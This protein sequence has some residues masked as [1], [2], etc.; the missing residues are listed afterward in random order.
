MKKLMM[1][2]VALLAVAAFAVAGEEKSCNHA[3]GEATA[4]AGDHS[5]AEPG[6]MHANCPLKGKKIAETADVTLEGK[7]LCRHCNL[8][9]QDTCEKVFQPA[10]SE[11]LIAI[12]SGSDLKAAEAVAEHG[13]A[14]IS[15][16]GKLVKAEDGSQMLKI[17]KAKKKA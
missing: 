16:S 1:L 9:Q 10:G 12:C 8:K 6:S 7:L 13:E 2:L 15:V 5:C 11:T 4:A 14:V 17:E 3:K